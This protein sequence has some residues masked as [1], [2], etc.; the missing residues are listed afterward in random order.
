MNRIF[1]GFRPFVRLVEIAIVAILVVI[2]REVTVFLGFAV[3]V[4]TG[5]LLWAKARVF[6]KAAPATSPRPDAEHGDSL[7]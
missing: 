1:R 6:P 3:Y 5:P 4:T 7:F 2:F